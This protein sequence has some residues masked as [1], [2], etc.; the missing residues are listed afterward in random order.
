MAKHLGVTVGQVDDWL[1]G[2]GHPP[3]EIFLQCADL[4]H[5]RG[6]SF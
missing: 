5:A 1:N 2:R 4:L 6:K 3:E